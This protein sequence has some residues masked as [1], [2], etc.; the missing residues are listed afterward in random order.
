MKPHIREQWADLLRAVA[1]TAAAWGA[2]WL[3]GLAQWLR[4]HPPGR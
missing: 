3:T 4:D 2:A 1:L